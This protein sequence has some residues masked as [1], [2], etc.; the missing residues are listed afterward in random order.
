MNDRVDTGATGSGLALSEGSRVGQYEIR[1]KLGAGGM[2][3]VFLALD[4]RLERE[5]ALKFLDPQL[6]GQE[7]YRARLLREARAAAK[8]SHPNIVTVFDVGNEHDSVFLAMEYVHGRSLREL[9]DTRGLS[10]ERALDVFNQICS[11]LRHAHSAQ[12]VHRDLK[13]ANIIVTPDQQ[14][15]ILDFGLAKSTAE[16]KQTQSGTVLGTANYMSP[17]QTQGRTVD[18]RSDIFSAGI[19]LYELLTGVNPFVRGFVPATI[20]AIAYEPHQPLDMYVSDMPL[21]YQTVIDKALAKNTADRYQNMDELLTDLRR[22]RSGESV[23]P[24]NV[25]VIIQPQATAVPARSLAVL[26]LQNLGSE[27]DD[28]LSYGITEDLIVD[29][30]R[31]GALRVVPMRKILKYKDSDLEL[32]DIARQLNVT[33]LLDGS[34]RR[35]ETSI[36]VSAQLIDATAGRILWSDRWDEAPGNLVKVETALAEGI[37][38]ALGV[39]SSTVKRAEVGQAETSNPQ[40]YEYYLKGKFAFEKRTKKSDLD[41]ALDYFNKALAIVPNMITAQIGI[42]KLR[43]DRSEMNQ[44]LEVLRPALADAESRGLRADAARIRVGIG[45]AINRLG[46]HPAAKEMFTAAA[47][48]FRDLGDPTGEMEAIS[49]LLRI[50]LNMGQNDTAL[51]LEPRINELTVFGPDARVILDAKFHLSEAF[52]RAGDTGRCM[53]ILEEV[54]QV[55]RAES[56][57]HME[58]MCLQEIAGKELNQIGMDPGR[59]LA[60]IEEARF[61]A[62]RLDD[63][64]LI[65]KITQ[66]GVE[67]HVF[68]GNFRGALDAISDALELAAG[69]QDHI[70]RASLFANRTVC[71]YY[72]GRYDDCI[73]CAAE[74]SAA[75][76]SL[77][78]GLK[79]I[80]VSIADTMAALAHFM[81]GERED[82][83]RIVRTTRDGVEYASGL[84]NSWAAETEI[85]FQMRDY[86]AARTCAVEALKLAS[87]IKEIE[88]TVYASSYLGVLDVIDG[89]RELGLKRL[90]EALT[91]SEGHMTAVLARRLLGQALLEFSASDADRQQGRNTLMQ[92]LG[93]ARRQE[94]EPEIALIQD[95]LS[96]CA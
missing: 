76:A 48:T 79:A 12:V 38:K 32:E 19:I 94:N 71:L 20:H 40:A 43:I 45:L 39:D 50:A 91:I 35:S 59:V 57:A 87:E 58:A 66:I 84:A 47:D 70:M 25:S 80:I 73:A 14:A 23:T 96:R 49:G 22:V 55:A 6:L 92:A 56:L 11:G 9:I 42:A 54:L 21:G 13:P 44:A 1:R 28:H 34:I 29:L 18:H 46:D 10:R 81:K 95:V 51:R 17:E 68:S 26:H 78:G 82:A 85:H 64:V 4:T 89:D 61:V 53:A 41:T 63:E 30:G 33:L 31:L 5:V 24:A 15:K 86:A 27:D 52:H 88:S 74:T 83:L 8:L 62:E 37:V 93:L 77:S 69:I 72:L 67:A 65:A 90:R 3:Q 7:D 60:Y 16:G 75:S 2:G 36:R